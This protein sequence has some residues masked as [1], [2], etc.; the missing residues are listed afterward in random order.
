MPITGPGGGVASSAPQEDVAPK[1][2]QI[3]TKKV[4]FPTEK[5]LQRFRK[6]Q[7]Q[8]EPLNELVRDLA[9]KGEYAECSLP[10]ESFL[11]ELDE[12]EKIDKL[13]EGE[14]MEEG[15]ERYLVVSNSEGGFT[16]VLFRCEGGHYKKQD[17]A[18][19]EQKSGNLQPK[20]K[21]VLVKNH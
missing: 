9:S 21:I 7:D 12:Q 18:F 8:G 5:D 4:K 13:M 16:R 17:R 19:S 20:D 3:G 2:V 15:T 11:E 6:G 14:P 1:E 10:D